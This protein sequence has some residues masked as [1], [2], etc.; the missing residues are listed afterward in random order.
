MVIGSLEKMEGK[1]NEAE[2]SLPR[3]TESLPLSLATPVSCD[4]NSVTP[5]KIYLPPDHHDSCRSGWAASR[6]SRTLVT[7]AITILA[8][9]TISDLM[10]LTV[11]PG[12]N[13]V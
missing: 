11:P 2:L 4:G 9:S 13:G 8:A 6:T 1:R 10:V 12:S 3:F 7:Q 5:P